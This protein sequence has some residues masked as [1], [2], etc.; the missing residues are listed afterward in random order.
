MAADQTWSPGTIK[1]LRDEAVRLA[2][3]A[4]TL[5]DLASDLRSVEPEG[6]AGRAADAYGELRDRLTKQCL[7]GAAAYEAAA[8]AADDYVQILAE[9]EGRRRHETASD[10]LARLEQQRVEAAERLEAV[11]RAATEEFEA[12]RT[13]LPEPVTAPARPAAA[14]PESGPREARLPRFGDPQYV[15]D[16]S[17][18]VLEYFARP[19]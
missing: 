1:L 6:W 8:G 7:T 3:I 13:A 2:D 11:W 12:I 15:Q 16:L 18:A 4:T 14:V 5:D 19:A 10:A 17:D 9:L